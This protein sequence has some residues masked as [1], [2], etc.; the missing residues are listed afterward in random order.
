MLRCR[1]IC[2][3]ISLRTDGGGALT[4]ESPPL[5]LNAYTCTNT[6]TL[7]CLALP[8]I[9]AAIAFP[10]SLYYGN[11]GIAPIQSAKCMKPSFHSICLSLSSVRTQACSLAHPLRP[12]LCALPGEQAPSVPPRSQKKIN[13]RSSHGVHSDELYPHSSSQ[14]LPLFKA[15][16]STNLTLPLPA[17][18]CLLGLVSAGALHAYVRVRSVSQSVTCLLASS[19]DAFIFTGEQ[20]PSVPA[21][22]RLSEYSKHPR[23]V[24]VHSYTFSSHCD[25][26]LCFICASSPLTSPIRTHQLS[27]AST[28]TYITNH[29]PP[30]QRKLQ[31]KA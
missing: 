9:A 2:A 11:P 21:S 22:S 27:P 29:F 8:C 30:P 1:K 7:E 15:L 3:Q 12:S 19:S 24:S 16:K 18:M 26:F 6:L 10:S 4:D 25:S 5:D 31:Q 14:T 17:F 23:L 28:S 13:S 20:A